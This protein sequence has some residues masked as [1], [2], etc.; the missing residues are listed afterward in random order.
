MVAMLISSGAKLSDV[1]VSKLAETMGIHIDRRRVQEIRKKHETALMASREGMRKTANVLPMQVDRERPDMPLKLVSLDGWDVELYY[2][3]E[4]SS[5][6]RLTVV[7]VVDTMNDYPL[8]YAIGEQESAAL[9]QAAMRDAVRHTRDLFGGYYGLWQVQSDHYALKAMTPYYEA[10]AKYVTPARVGNA[11]AKPIERY[12][13]YL[14]TEYLW[15]FGNNSGHNITAKTNANDEWLNANRKSF[16]D[17]KGCE[18]QVAKMM[19]VERSRKIGAMREA[20]EKGS[21][22]MKR[23]LN[24][25]QYLMTYGEKTRGNMLTPNGLKV[26]RDGVEYKFDCFDLEMREHRS[27]RWTLWYDLEDMNQALAV[28]EDGTLRYMVEA[29]KKVPMALVDYT[30]QDWKNLLEYREFNAKL[31]Q[32]MEERKMAIAKRAEGYVTKAMLEGDLS[33]KLLTDA[34]GQH[35]DKKHEQ[36]I[37]KLAE[38]A[39]DVEVVEEAVDREAVK[40]AKVM[41]DIWN[42]L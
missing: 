33:G 28:N 13:G 42:R 7:I 18:A 5:Y 36:R 35:K 10:V 34:M 29:K 25:E 3:T 30:E 14:E 22:E 38:L 2:R 11:K 20:W 31:V 19:E 8:G 12:F 23:P 17:R 32:T 24:M 4:K 21:E 37:A 9:I 1:Q 39:E 16:P 6:N 15:V 40:K 41:K 27:E 26:V